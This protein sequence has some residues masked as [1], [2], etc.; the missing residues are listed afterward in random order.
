MNKSTRGKYYVS[1]V[2]QL[3]SGTYAAGRKTAGS[4]LAIFMGC[5]LRFS[6]FMARPISSTPPTALI[7]VTMASVSSGASAPASSVSAPPL[8][9][10]RQS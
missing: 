3:Y 5:C 1:D 4:M 2:I 6:K 10:R 8:R 9:A 7:S